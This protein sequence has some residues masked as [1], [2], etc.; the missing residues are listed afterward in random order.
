MASLLD[1]ADQM[2]KLSQRL[3]IFA[4]KTTEDVALTIVNDVTQVTPVDVGEALSNWIISLDAP[5]V[6]TIPAFAPSPK[7]RVKDGKWQHAVDPVVTAQNNLPSVLSAATAVL[8][9]RVPG[10]PIYISNNLPYIQKLNEGSSEQAPAGFVDRAIILG[11][12]V[13]SKAK[14]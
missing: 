11:R 5:S 9:G 3:P 4:K 13:A 8:A 6:E 2:D 12:E 10:Q 1:L 14:L 7:G